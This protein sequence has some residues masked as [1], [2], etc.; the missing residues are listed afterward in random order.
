[1]TVSREDPQARLSK[2]SA[3]TLQNVPS[4][5]YMLAE[6]DRDNPLRA[7]MGAGL[8]A[9]IRLECEVGEVAEALA[10]FPGLEL[11]NVYGVRVPGTEGRAGMAALVFAPDAAFD[12]EAFFAFSAE[13]LPDYAVPLFVRLP[14]SLDMTATFKLRKFHLQRQG[15]DPAATSD[16]LFVRDEEAQS[17]L[18]LTPESLARAGLPEFVADEVAA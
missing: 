2:L 7:M 4:Q 11:A 16:P 12:P 6:R 15:Y 8:G 18:P 9:D 1:V 14:E 13:R 5:S 3:G 17:Y 10:V